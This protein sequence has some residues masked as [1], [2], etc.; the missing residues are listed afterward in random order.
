MERRIRPFRLLPA[1][2]FVAGAAAATFSPAGAQV[3]EDSAAV[4]PADTLPLPWMPAP[5][6]IFLGHHRITPP[7]LTPLLGPR[8]E[9]DRIELHW[10]DLSGRWWHALETRL[11]DGDRVEV[12]RPLKIDPKEARR[13]RAK[14]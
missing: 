1:V 2:L 14:R 11:A 3:R 10:T 13:R 7:G 9:Q 5:A 4:R 8:L 6:G 12:Y